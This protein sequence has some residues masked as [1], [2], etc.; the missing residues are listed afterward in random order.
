MRTRVRAAI[1][2]CVDGAP[3]ATCLRET[4]GEADEEELDHTGVKSLL[5]QLGWKPIPATFDANLLTRDGRAPTKAQ[6]LGWVKEKQARN[7]QRRAT[8]KKFT[9]QFDSRGILTTPEESFGMK[10][11]NPK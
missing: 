4:L 11:R 5:V 8:E 10:R 6:V 3:I 9:D 1:D 7:V 2:A